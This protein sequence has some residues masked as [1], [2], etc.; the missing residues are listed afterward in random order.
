MKIEKL[1]IK[2]Y[3]GFRGDE[4]LINFLPDVNIFVGI[5]GS[6]KTSL[7][8]LIAIFLN[9]FTIKLA[10]FSNREIEYSLNQLDINLYEKETVNSI[11]IK[12]PQRF[13]YNPFFDNEHFTIQWEMCRDFQNSRNNY[14]E[15]ND[16]IKKYQDILLIT[17]NCF[18]PII[19]YF[20]SQRITNEKHKHIN[21][22]KRYLSEQLK[23]YDDAF[24][25]SSEFDEFI[26][27]FIEEENIENREKIA[28]KDFNYESPNLSVIRKAIK[29][30]FQNFKP[31]IYENFR[32]ED[33]T[34]MTKLSE[35]SSLVID[36]NKK[37]FNL[38]QLSDGEKILILTVS[39]IAHRLSIANPKNENALTGCGI[40]LI[41][42]ID[43]HLHPAWQR[44]I[45]PHLLKTFP[46]IQFFITSHSPQVLSSV[47]KENVFKIKD[48]EISKLTAYTKG[49]DSNSILYDV[50]DVYEREEIYKKELELLYSYIEMNDKEKAKNLMDKLTQLWG[51][52]DR[53]IVRANMYYEDLM[54]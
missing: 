27:W 20:Q 50:F 34:I 42:E 51:N 31:D 49:R 45:I 3:K 1:N 18:V 32:V 39:D 17:P 21:T 23:V 4:C 38:K 53:E 41:D 44:A 19:K 29:L 46:N 24:D 16:Y 26:K 40:V 35:K 9:Q 43:L 33:R 37:T 7:L 2:N 6:G 11:F 28:L 12:P 48:F 30:F 10:G 25:R 15:L 22:Q 5:N 52:N 13:N 14:K 36:K 54:D 47:D 8:D